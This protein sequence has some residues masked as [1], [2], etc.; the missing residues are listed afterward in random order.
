MQAFLECSC[1][2]RMSRAWIILWNNIVLGDAYAWVIHAYG[3]IMT[4]WWPRNIHHTTTTMYCWESLSKLRTST[5]IDIST[6]SSHYLSAGIS[7]KSSCR[8][9]ED[10]HD[11]KTVVKNFRKMTSYRLLDLHCLL[12]VKLSYNLLELTLDLIDRDCMNFCNSSIQVS[13]YNIHSGS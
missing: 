4:W 3:R 7:C 6:S 9:E 1:M 8:Y 5:N 10:C 11:A 13:S 12:E 2:L